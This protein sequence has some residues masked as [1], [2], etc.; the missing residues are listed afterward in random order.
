[1]IRASFGKTVA[2]SMLIGGLALLAVPAVAGCEA[3]NNA[4]TLEFHKAAS[5]AYSTSTPVHVSNAFVLGAPTGQSVPT[6]SAASLFL[7]L[8]NTGA[9]ADKLVSATAEA[10][11]PTTNKV[12]GPAASSVEISG[13]SVALP[14]GQSTNLTGPKPSLVLKGLKQPLDSGNTVVITLKF[15]NAGAVQL[16]TPVQAQANMYATYSPPAAGSPAASPAASGTAS[17]KAAKPGATPGATPSATPSASASPAP[18]KK[19]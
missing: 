15:A 11:N 3:G 6:G 5:G 12:E 14:P 7:G 18:S 10:V 19:K 13:G 16:N 9:S 17:P 8:F 2:R 1:M 4:P